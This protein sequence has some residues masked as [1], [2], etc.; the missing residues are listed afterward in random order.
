M[1]CLVVSNPGL[2][3]SVAGVRTQCW[4]AVCTSACPHGPQVDKGFLAEELISSLEL[5]LLMCW[6]LLS[7]SVLSSENG[8]YLHVYLSLLAGFGVIVYDWAVRGEVG[9]CYLKSVTS[10]DQGVWVGAGNPRE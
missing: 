9:A 10:Q 8:L 4:E 1:G 3:G 5:N 2:A 7:L 6:W